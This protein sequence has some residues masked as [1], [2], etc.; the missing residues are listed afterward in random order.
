[1][2]TAW[3]ALLLS[4]ALLSA[5][6]VAA[7]P[8]PEVSPVIVADQADS[9]GVL[10][11]VWDGKRWLPLPAAAPKVKADTRYGVQELSGASVTITGGSPVSY[12]EP[13]PDS[14][15]V[16]FAS[17][18]KAPGPLLAVRSGLVA[19]PRPV[20][21]LPT[22]SPVY[23]Q[24]IRQE[25]QRRGLRNP[26][27]YLIRLV[28]SDLDGDGSQEVIIEATFFAGPEG[29]LNAVPVNA[30]AGDYSLLLLRSVVNGK[31][32]TTV[33]GA[34]V[35]LK[36]SSD[37]ELAPRLGLRESLEGLA[38]F[39]GDGKMEIVTS[40]SYYEGTTYHVW[41]W[42]PGAGLKKVLESGCGV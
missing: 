2:K 21:L 17:P 31:L 26:E 34:D 28:R 15:A 29:D 42:T 36:A 4:T 19:R 40:E 23:R 7:A 8:T 35:V 16:E 6:G 32:R 12:D 30:A 24:V 20:T 37:P 27:V 25:L 10:L 13:C 5:G 33:L 1:M 22:G 41:T 9:T 38:D 14:F 11:G 39:N 3:L 18:P